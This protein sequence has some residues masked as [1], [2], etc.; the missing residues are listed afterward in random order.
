MSKPVNPVAIGG[1]T[2]GALALLAVG[3]L[4]FG[5]G[6]FFNTSK[7]RI[8][9]FFDSS[10]NG[11][12]VGAPVKM[13]GVKIGTVTE[14][15]LQ[16]DPGTGKVYKPVVVEIDR[17]R[18]LGPGGAPVSGSISHEDQLK[19]RDML[20]AK[21]FRARLETQSLLTGL[22]YVDFDKYPDKPAQFAK[23]DYQGLIELPCVPTTVDE[24]RDI[25]DELV[26]KLKA[27]PLE[28]MIQNFADT[29]KEI[30]GL[31]G[32]EEIKKSN[33]A[34]A[35]ALE[36]ME[37]T[38]GTLN[39]NLEP[40][41]KETHQTIHD[42]DGLAQDSRAMVQD[43]HQSMK[44]LLAATEK[45]LGSANAALDKAKSAIETMEGSVGADSSLNETLIALRK[46]A[47]SLKDLTDYLERHPESL[48]SGKR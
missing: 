35:K 25:A 5:G 41:L 27:L 11:L 13:Q 48:I 45:T 28:E 26:K 1:F 23:L 46:S 7:N 34:L 39:R 47:R 14:I 21:G 17:N 33:A 2:V 3:L 18:F 32:S 16:I 15:S 42:A 10:L 37:K 4:L 19:N 20:V 9:I 22:L 31:V 24:I 29:L 12:D 8:V 38:M 30:H 36:G 6:Q 44:P 40:L 43:I